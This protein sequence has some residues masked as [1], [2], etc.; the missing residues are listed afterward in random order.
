MLY[1]IATV[2]SDDQTDAVK[3]PIFETH[4]KLEEIKEIKNLVLDK[5]GKVLRITRFLNTE[6]ATLLSCILADNGDAA[7]DK[8]SIDAWDEIKLKYGDVISLK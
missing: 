2:S 1:Y 5:S 7:I 8:A 6:G 3:G 4:L